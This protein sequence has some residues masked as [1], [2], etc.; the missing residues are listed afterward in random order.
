MS[1]KK[2]VI[3]PIFLK[4]KALTAWCVGLS[5]FQAGVTAVA[6]VGL[7]ELSSGAFDIVLVEILAV[8]AAVCGN[9]FHV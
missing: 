6:R 1:R 4:R 9:F 3:R 8:F 5:V 7:D 2:S